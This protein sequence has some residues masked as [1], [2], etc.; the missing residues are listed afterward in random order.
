MSLNSKY[1]ASLSIL[2]FFNNKLIN[3]IFCFL[4]SL[5]ILII[6]D[7][8]LTLIKSWSD[9][10]VQWILSLGLGGSATIESQVV[11]IEALFV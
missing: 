8:L 5:L 2:Y 6:S 7:E 9:Y 4:I 3:K 1:L 10:K 11:L